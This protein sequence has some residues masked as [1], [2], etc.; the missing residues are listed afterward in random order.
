MA[1]RYFAPR[2]TR[3]RPRP[4]HRDGGVGDDD[5]DAPPRRAVDGNALVK[6]I[7][8]VERVRRITSQWLRGPILVRRITRLSLL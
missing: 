8:S 6:Q 5:D 4:R 2:T 3:A 1:S 7:V